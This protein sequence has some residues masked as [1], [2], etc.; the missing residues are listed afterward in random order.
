MSL[1]L[2]YGLSDFTSLLYSCQ[3][4]VLTLALFYVD[5]PETDKASGA[6]SES[7]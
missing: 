2:F 1:I 3:Y 4:V 6:G 5:N 7:T